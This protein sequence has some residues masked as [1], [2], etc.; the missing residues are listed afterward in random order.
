MHPALTIKTA[1]ELPQRSEAW[2]KARAGMVTASSMSDVMAKGRSGGESA[3]RRKLMNKLTAERLTGVPAPEE[4]RNA[5]MDRGRELEDVAI[6]D[7]EARNV[8][9]VEKV[10]FAYREDYDA[11][12]SPDGLI[13]DREAGLEVKTCLPHILVDVH[14]RKRMP[15]E[16]TAQVQASLLILDIDWIH[17]YLFSE[18][19]DNADDDAPGLRPYLEKIERDEEYLGR[20]E[21]ELARFNEELAKLCEDISAGKEPAPDAVPVDQQAPAF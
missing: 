19:I 12:C 3:G 1:E 11:G 10:G 14:R 21:A 9:D 20:I 16:H 7:Y 18:G 17:F 2:R 8:Y 15:P 13:L 5:A 4:F 6:A